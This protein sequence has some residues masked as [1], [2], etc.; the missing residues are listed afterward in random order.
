MYKFLSTSIIYKISFARTDIVY[1]QTT[2]CPLPE[3]SAFYSLNSHI[4]LLRL[5]GISC[6]LL[7]SLLFILL[8]D[9]GSSHCFLSKTHRKYV[10]S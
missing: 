8:L 3:H 2:Q 1:Y 7:H 9:K 4:V 10:R 5:D 6:A